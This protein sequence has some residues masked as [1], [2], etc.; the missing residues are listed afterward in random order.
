MRCSSRPTTPTWA[1]PPAACSTSPRKSG[2]NAW[3]GSAL[4]MNK[5]GWAHRPAVLRQAR[6]QPEPAAVLLLVGRIGRRPDREGQDVL[7]VQQGR[8]HAEEHAQQRAHVP[9]RA[10]ARR[11]LLAVAQRA[12]QPITIYDPL[13]TRPNPN[14][15]GFIRDPFPGNVIPADRLN[16]IALAM[17]AQHADCRPRA[18]RSTA[19]RSLDDGPQDQETLKIDHRWSD[20]WTTTG[21]YG[22]QHTQEPGSAFWGPHGTIPG[23]PGGTHRCYRDGQLLLDRTSI[24]MPNNIDG[25]RR[26]LRLQPLPRRRHQL[27]RRLRRGDA[28]LSR[29]ASPSVLTDNTFPAV[30]MTGYSNIGHGGRSITTCTS[31]RPP[32]PRVSKFMGKHSM[33]GRRATTGAVAAYA[34][35]AQ[36]RQLRV[37]PGVHAGAERRTPRAAPPATRSPASCSATR[38][39]ATSTWRR[40]AATTSTTT[41]RYVQDDYRVDV[42]ADAELRPA[43][44]VRAGHR[45]ERTTASPS[46]SIATRCSRCRCPA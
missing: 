35:R 42:E 44:R 36:Q 31:A 19:R 30:T 20:K 3:H 9:D 32:T 18:A 37:H 33:Q 34:V 10:R 41:R 13:T 2:S 45:R 21:M 4:F 40:R 38:P 14:G 15:T 6:R 12:G 23:D 39:P 29:R 43:L 16:P 1:A 25:D 5:P 27:R 17:L 11:R 8:L 28:R 46:A 24:I 22:H 26:P 7:L